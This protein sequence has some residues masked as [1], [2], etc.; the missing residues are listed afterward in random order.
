MTM[1]GNTIGMISRGWSHG[2]SFRRLR[3]ASISFVP[4]FDHVPGPVLCGLLVTEPSMCN[5]SDAG[6]ANTV[7][8]P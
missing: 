1:D 5:P 6:E 7:V 8:V 4:Q 3:S 2:R